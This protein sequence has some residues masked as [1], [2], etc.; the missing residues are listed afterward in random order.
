MLQGR[1]GWDVVTVPED[2][3]S[4]YWFDRLQNPLRLCIDCLFWSLLDQLGPRPALDS[5]LL[6][7][8]RQMAR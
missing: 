8:S 6:S 4:G 7:S 3:T 1:I 2:K 5:D